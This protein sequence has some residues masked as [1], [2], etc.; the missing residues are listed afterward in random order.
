MTPAGILELSNGEA[1]V[2]LK[3]KKKKTLALQLAAG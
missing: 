2:D 1:A 3:K